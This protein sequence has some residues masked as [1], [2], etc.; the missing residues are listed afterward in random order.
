MVRRWWERVTEPRHVSV[1]YGGVY[2]IA[3][4]TGILTVLVPPVTIRGELGPV[5]TMMWAGLF[6]IGGAIGMCTVLNGWWAWERWGSILIITGIGI[7]GFVITTLHF[8]TEGS[9]LTQLGVLA[10]A[11][12]VFVVR[13]T[14]IRGRTYGPRA[15]IG[16]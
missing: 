15:H 4:L 9:R 3:L 14:M 8:T 7:Y 13:W 10:L 11:A 6:V 1:I 12:S 16:G 5:L 2:T